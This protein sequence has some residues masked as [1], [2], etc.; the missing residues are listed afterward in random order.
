M[1]AGPQVGQKAQ[2]KEFSYLLVAMAEIFSLLLYY[3]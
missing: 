2:P 3:T 1:R